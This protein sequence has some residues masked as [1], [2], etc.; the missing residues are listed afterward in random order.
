MKGLFI[1]YNQIDPANL[2]GIDKKVVTQIE[3]FKS[4]GFGCDL[5]VLEHAVYSTLDKILARFP[6]A[7]KT[8]KWE[9]K[10]EFNEVDFIYFRRPVACTGKMIS[11]LE[12]IKTHNSNVKIIMEIPNYPYDAEYFRLPANLPYL[13]R[14]K[15]HRRKLHSV[16]DRIAVQ[17][18]ISQIFGI[19]TL[20]FTNGIKVD[21]YQIKKG[22]GNGSDTI[23]MCAVAKLEPWQGYERVIKSLKRYYENG[24]SRN[25]IIHFVGEGK[26]K[27]YYES[28]VKRLGLQEHCKFHGFLNGD[29][30]EEI[31]DC[32][33]LGLDAFG[34]YKTRNSLSTSLKSREYLAKGLPIVSGSPSDL[35]TK[36]DPYYLEFP[37]NKSLFDF[38]VIV[39]FHDNL[40]ELKSKKDVAKIINALAYELCDISWTM[41]NIVNYI[42]SKTII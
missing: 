31:Y 39:K 14:D 11:T 8:P 21:D 17:N 23:V 38:N 32:S 15:F 6:G 4:N 10:N 19:P 25:I 40:Y 33:D 13:I 18:N 26:E 3:V 9:Y 37:S 1:F 34:R 5:L 2:S 41:K 24:G 16:V 20:N 7:N 35:L 28:L 29:R 30:L 27:R 36:S 22:N 42:M 12:T